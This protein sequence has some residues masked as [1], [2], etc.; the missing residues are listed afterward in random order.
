MDYYIDPN[1]PGEVFDKPFRTFVMDVSEYSTTR[2]LDAQFK[3][4]YTTPGTEVTDSTLPE[5]KL[6]KGPVSYTVPANL[7]DLD[8]VI[9]EARARTQ[10]S[11]DETRRN[12]RFKIVLLVV[13]GVGLAGLLVY[14]VRRYRRQVTKS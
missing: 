13:N 10:S 11:A 3:L 7:D 12:V 6:G 14:L 4:N 9:D 8:R 2:V 5:A 1:S